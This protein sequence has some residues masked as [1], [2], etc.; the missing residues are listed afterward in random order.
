MVS[1]KVIREKK[2]SYAGFNKKYSI[3]IKYYVL[4]IKTDVIYNIISHYYDQIKISNLSMYLKEHLRD[5]FISQIIYL[6]FRS[7]LG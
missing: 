5:K 2:F 7:S 1:K 4:E 6:T 3:C